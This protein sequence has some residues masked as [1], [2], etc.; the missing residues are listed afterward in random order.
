MRNETIK[1][2]RVGSL[3]HH[4]AVL[5]FLFSF[6][7]IIYLAIFLYL[8]LWNQNIG[9][10][11]VR[12]FKL[13]IVFFFSLHL[14]TCFFWMV[15]SDTSQSEVAKDG[16]VF[17]PLMQHTLHNSFF[18]NFE[19]LAFCCL[20]M[21]NGLRFSGHSFALSLVSFFLLFCGP[22]SF[23]SLSRVFPVISFQ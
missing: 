2:C 23:A 14:I 9:S 18:P 13:F 21:D 16:L 12:V 1:L 8:H 7:P 22:I 4:R 20:E 11:L 6:H 15:L 17:P 10:A 5:V 19:Y 3:L